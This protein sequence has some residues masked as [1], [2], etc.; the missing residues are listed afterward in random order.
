ML[1]AIDDAARADTLCAKYE[2]RGAAIQPPAETSGFYHEMTAHVHVSHTSPKAADQLQDTLTWLARDA[3]VHLGTPFG[4]EQPN[5]GAW[6][7][8]D[9]CQ[10]AVEFLLAYDHADVVAEILRKVFAQQ[11]DQRWDWP[12]WFMF[13]PFQEIQSTHPHG[14]TLIW[15]LKALCDYLEHT[16]D[17]AILQ[18]RLPYTSDQTF[19]RTDSAETMLQHVD[20]L[21]GAACATT[22]CPASSCRDMAK[23]TGTIHFSRPTRCFASGWS[24]PGPPS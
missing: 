18:E 1:G 21:L 24:V 15:P 12:Q 7:V 17:A 23:E 8:R 16:N 6:G 9:V 2:R 3:V 10:G 4:L 14:D 22:F 19:A 20:R 13:P 5:G 11:Y